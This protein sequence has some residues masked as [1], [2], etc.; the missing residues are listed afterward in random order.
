MDVVELTADSEEGGVPVE[1][2]E[3][4]DDHVVEL[5]GEAEEATIGLLG[6]VVECLHF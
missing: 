4:R 3:I 5:D 2:G 6:S 1:E